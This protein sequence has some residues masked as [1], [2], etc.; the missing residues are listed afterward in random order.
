MTQDSPFITISI[1]PDG[2]IST[3]F[4]PH[5]KNVCV[6]PIAVGIALASA[7][8]VV[9]EAFLQELKLPDT[10]REQLHALICEVYN[11]DMSWKSMGEEQSTTVTD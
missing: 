11:R 5:Q 4:N 9:T 6:D 1:T 10:H 8:R 7:T 2:E 3:R